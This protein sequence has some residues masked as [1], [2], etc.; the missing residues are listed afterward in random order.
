VIG[1][2]SASLARD[3]SNATMGEGFDL[4]DIR[5]TGKQEELVKAV[6]ATGKPVIVVLIEGKPFAI[7]WLKENIP[8]IVEA[9]YP[10]EMGGL[11][12][13]EIL[14]GITNPSGK[15]PVSYPK[16]TGNLPCYYNH[17]PTDRGYYRKPGSYGKPGR[18]Y[19]FET[20]GSLWAFGHGLSYTTFSFSNFRMSS[21][22][23]TFDDVLKISVDVTN[24][25]LRDGKE[26][27]QLYLRDEYSKILRPVKELKAFGKVLILP[28]ETKTIELKV[29]M[30]DC[31]YY[32]NKGNYLLE[33]GT[34][35]IMVGAASDDIRFEEI[36][37]VKAGR[38][39]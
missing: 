26:V 29:R 36:V 34:F 9:W 4:S 28:G 10:G 39:H 8:A 14:F 27:V 19:V 25:G 3:Y 21:S 33:P 24:T 1:S 17:L 15:T 5:L 32:D 22:E 35:R 20:P 7:P 2:S 16:S 30:S 23:L 13:A 31:G 18:D 11:S 37:N 38:D 12:V 6:H